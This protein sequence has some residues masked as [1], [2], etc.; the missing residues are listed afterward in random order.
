[1]ADGENPAN[2]SKNHDCLVTI[3]SRRPV[4]ICVLGHGTSPYEQKTQ[5]SPFIGFTTLAHPLHL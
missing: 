2:Y 3:F 1:M 4:Y 5:H